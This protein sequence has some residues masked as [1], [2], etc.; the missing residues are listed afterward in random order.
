MAITFIYRMLINVK[1]I[2]KSIGLICMDSNL[3]VLKKLI[4]LALD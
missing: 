2:F 4:Y 3:N 1:Y